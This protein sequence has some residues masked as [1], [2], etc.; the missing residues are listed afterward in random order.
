LGKIRGKERLANTS[1]VPGREHG[2]KPLQN[3]WQ[4]HA[5]K[6]RDFPKRIA[7]KA[8]NAILRNFEDA[9]IYRI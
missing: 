6:A 9:G 3:S 5:G 1:D 4:R 8:L 7:L 2:A